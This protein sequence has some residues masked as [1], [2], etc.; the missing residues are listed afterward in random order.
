MT[1]QDV[2]EIVKRALDVVE[3]RTSGLDST[4]ASMLQH[5]IEKFLVLFHEEMDKDIDHAKKTSEVTQKAHEA[6]HD[7]RM[8]HGL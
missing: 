6:A 5:K 3:S 1:V 4:A 8:S 7:I 2:K